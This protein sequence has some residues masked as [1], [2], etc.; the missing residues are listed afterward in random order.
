MLPD[1]RGL[2]ATETPLSGVLVMEPKVF[3][4][5]RGFLLESYNERSMAAVGIQA[6]FVQDNHSYSRRNV[7]RGLHYQINSSQSKL[8]RVVV[9]EIFD[10]AVDLRRSSAT[11]GKWFGTRLS[12][13]NRQMLWVPA[14]FAHGFQVLSEGAHVLYKATDFY[15]PQSERTIAWDDP[16]IPIQWQLS[17]RP[18]VSDKDSKGVLFKTAETFP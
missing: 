15:A 2:K 17:Q 4:D 18:V 7:L 1:N 5:D 16:D 8:V 3:E 6:Q 13:E 12:G 11:F 10:V 14:G 9:G